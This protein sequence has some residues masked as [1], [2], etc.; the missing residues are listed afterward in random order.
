MWQ[1][2]SLPSINNNK[3]P[4]PRIPPANN[5]LYATTPPLAAPLITAPPIGLVDSHEV[6]IPLN[7]FQVNDLSASSASFGVTNSAEAAVAA[8]AAMYYNAAA[9]ATTV[10][11]NNLFPNP[12]PPLSFMA[13][14]QHYMRTRRPHTGVE[15]EEVL[16]QTNIG[17]AFAPPTTATATQLLAC[18]E[19][20]TNDTSVATTATPNNGH[21]LL[22]PSTA[23]LTTNM[24]MTSATQPQHV[25]PTPGPLVGGGG[26]GALD[27]LP[28]D[29]LTDTFL[30]LNA[31]HLSHMAGGVT[32]T[33]TASAFP[34]P[35]PLDSI[36]TTTMAAAAAVAAAATSKRYNHIPGT[37]SATAAAAAAAMLALPLNL[38]PPSPTT[39]PPPSPHH[40]YFQLEHHRQ[41]QN[42][43]QLQHHLK[44][45][46][47]NSPAIKLT[48][49]K[50]PGESYRNNDNAIADDD[51]DDDDEVQN[52]TTKSLPPRSSAFPSLPVKTA[53]KTSQPGVSNLFRAA[54][55]HDSSNFI[56]TT[57]SST[58][59][60]LQ[61]ALRKRTRERERER[62]QYKRIKTSTHHQQQQ[63]QKHEPHHHHH[64]LQNLRP[65]Y[66]PNDVSN[67][68]T[69]SHRLDSRSTHQQEADEEEV[70]GEGSLLPPPKKKWIRHYLNGIYFQYAIYIC[71]YFKLYIENNG[72]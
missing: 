38:T 72:D 28:L 20:I 47:T 58:N 48:T 60:D 41:H 10:T 53:I 57:S 68:E 29:I 34:P 23:G 18:E 5:A 17:R 54:E 11:T 36:N 43:H 4:L 6:K 35:P 51:E 22:A 42:H 9:A 59:C 15:R 33:P 30:R 13:H 31:L 70:E 39:L 12:L 64:H 71:I 62:E 45:L 24:L 56:S 3:S 14:L 61:R 26:G 2:S 44:T 16:K 65:P 37:T 52:Y 67:Q 50:K 8:A 46:N 27:M 32:V 55:L 69:N 66:L 63:Q 19:E 21:L 7:K 1:P 49:S 25:T 40:A